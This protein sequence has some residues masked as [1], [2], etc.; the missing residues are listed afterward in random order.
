MKIL[1]LNKTFSMSSLTMRI[2]KLF[3]KQLIKSFA[4]GFVLYKITKLYIINYK[5]DKIKVKRFNL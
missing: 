2:D 3:L 5:K 4:K 1:C